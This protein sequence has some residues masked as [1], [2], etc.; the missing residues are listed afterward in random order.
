M[1][2]V[3]LKRHCKLLSFFTIIA[4]IS[5]VFEESG[6]VYSCNA[7]NSSVKRDAMFCYTVSMVDADIVSWNYI[8]SKRY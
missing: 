3:V 5:R 7:L 6:R 2:D 1:S 4:P 8:C